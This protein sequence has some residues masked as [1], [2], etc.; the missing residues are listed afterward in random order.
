MPNREPSTL[1]DLKVI[2]MTAIVLISLAARAQNST[3]GGI[4]P[5]VTLEDVSIQGE[6]AGNQA[7]LQNRNRFE[8]DSR[9]KLRKD[10]RP[11]LEEDIPKGYQN[12]PADF[13]KTKE[14]SR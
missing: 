6:S 13:F 7:L 11:E 3:A 1:A 4:A 2:L 9:L 5:R 8:L 12:L 14:A 10:F